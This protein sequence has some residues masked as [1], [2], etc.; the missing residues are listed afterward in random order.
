MSAA[1]QPIKHPASFAI[2]K[3]S[4]L[5]EQDGPF[6]QILKE[7]L[8][9]LFESD[10]EVVRAYLVRLSHSGDASVGVALALRTKVKEDAEFVAKIGD[11]F[12]SIFDTSVHLDILF[13]DEPAERQV[14]HACR[15]FYDRADAAFRG[16][17]LGLAF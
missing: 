17:A 8:T 5:G 11:V 12:S 3:V 16:R 9:K 13:L 1:R 15:T 2:D 6:E 4:F 14:R 10:R 7:R